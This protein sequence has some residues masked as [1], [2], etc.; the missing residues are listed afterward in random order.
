MISKLTRHWIWFISQC[1]RNLVLKVVILKDQNLW[2]VSYITRYLG[3]LEEFPLMNVQ[4]WIKSVKKFNSLKTSLLQKD[5]GTSV[6][7]SSSYAI[8]FSHFHIHF[9]SDSIHHVC[10]VTILTRIQARL[11]YSN[12][13]LSQSLAII[14]LNNLLYFSKY[15]FPHLSNSNLYPHI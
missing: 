9:F 15:Q 10:F 13:D 1:A 2:E 12:I 5:L 6:L 11:E 8:Q 14:A 4:K 3:F 7:S